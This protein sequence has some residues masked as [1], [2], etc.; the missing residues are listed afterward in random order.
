MKNNHYLPC[1][2]IPLLLV[3][4][5]PKICI[6]VVYSN[7]NFNNVDMISIVQNIMST[8][9]NLLMSLSFEKLPILLVDVNNK[10]S[11]SVYIVLRIIKALT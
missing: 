4:K 10:I 2:Q 7:N 3:S 1:A 8:S 6:Y 11:H 5:I 9:V